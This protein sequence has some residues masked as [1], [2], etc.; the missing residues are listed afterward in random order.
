VRPSA[1]RIIKAIASMKSTTVNMRFSSLK[2]RILWVID[3]ALFESRE[4]LN[5]FRNRK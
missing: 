5:S 2:Y 1:L 4:L 3:L